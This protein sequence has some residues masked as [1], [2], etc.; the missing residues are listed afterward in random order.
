[1]S[2]VKR[3]Q[4]ASID[5]NNILQTESWMQNLSS[6]LQWAKLLKPFQNVG[7]FKYSKNNMSSVYYFENQSKNTVKTV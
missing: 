5:L 2:D 7:H 3:D 1:M 4:N 6:V